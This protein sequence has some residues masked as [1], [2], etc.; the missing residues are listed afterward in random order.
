[1]NINFFITS[2]GGGGAERVV[3]NLANYLTASQHQVTISVLR[4]DDDTYSLE[5]NVSKQYLQLGYYK[6]RKSRLYRLKEILTVVKFLKHLP[7]GTLL[8]SF[9][10]LPVAYSL[11]LRRFYTQ[12]LIICERNNP[13]FYSKGYQ[14]IFE[15]LAHKADGCVCQ[16]KAIMDWYLPALDEKAKWAV[17]PNALSKDVL[18]STPS[19]LNGHLIMSMGRLEPQKNQRMLIEAFAE[20]ASDFP[21]Y[22]LSIYGKGPL[23]TE[24]KKQIED[25]GIENKVHLPG[26]TNDV[27]SA[28]RQSSMF[29]LTSE[30]EGMPNVLA[31]A[32][33]MGLPCIS[34]DCGGGGARELIQDGINGLLI[35]RGDKED[36][37]KSMRYLLKDPGY[38]NHLRQQAL[39]IRKQLTPETIHLKWM[40][41]FEKVYK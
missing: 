14:R 12:K 13:L 10:E 31:E 27:V 17:I 39:K 30:H 6:E 29:V 34:T 23:E 8:V 9:L 25:L 22:E 28:Y 33:A 15:K 32:M 40:E 36:L 35:K 26:F 4:G 38:A 11:I 3:C 7:K 5:K 24:L 41:F 18:D 37:L 21:E 19:P 2:L 16:T 1:M 20:I